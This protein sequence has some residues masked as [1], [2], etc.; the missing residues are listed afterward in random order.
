MSLKSGRSLR[1]FAVRRSL[2]Y[3]SQLGRSARALHQAKNEAAKHDTR[4]AIR[5]LRE[6]WRLFACYYPPGKIKKALNRAQK[7]RRALGLPREI[8]VCISLLKNADLTAPQSAAAPAAMELVREHHLDIF[9]G[10]RQR[11]QRKVRKRLRRMDL[12]A[13]HRQLVA[14]AHST[15]ADPVGPETTDISAAAAWLAGELRQRRQ[16]L[17]A[18]LPAENDQLEDTALHRLRIEVKKFRYALEISAPY[19][20]AALANLIQRARELQE[21]LGLNQDYG[22]L[23]AHLQQQ[24]ERLEAGQRPGLHQGTLALLARLAGAK[25]Q[26]EAGIRAA[27]AGLS[28][29]LDTLPLSSLEIKPPVKQPSR[30]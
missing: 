15:L 11:C 17:A 13:L 16:S 8:D 20:G 6:T 27:I 29:A 1:Q 18:L 5:R 24:A 28:D 19:L 21:A 23:L 9:E 10:E 4:V 14:A 3:I 2:E 25:A 22:V 7:L 12:A 26:G 30:A